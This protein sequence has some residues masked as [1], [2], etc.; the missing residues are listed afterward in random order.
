MH[1]LLVGQ[2]SWLVNAIGVAQT[3]AFATEKRYVVFMMICTSFSFNW[4]AKET[5]ETE[6]TALSSAL[7][8]MVV[9]HGRISH[10][11]SIIH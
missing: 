6:Y 10:P 7:S 4:L 5:Q 8:A 2:H 1:V 11:A 3:V 9:S